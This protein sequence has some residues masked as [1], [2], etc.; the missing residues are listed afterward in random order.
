M[1]GEQ[2]DGVTERIKTHFL[3]EIME[4]TDGEVEVVIDMLIRYFEES[5]E[6]VRETTQG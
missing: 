5:L 2:L 1:T 6:R 3:K 4:L